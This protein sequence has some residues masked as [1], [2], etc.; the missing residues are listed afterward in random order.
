[1][2]VK[3]TA[4]TV[5]RE[6]GE[7]KRQGENDFEG[8]FLECRRAP[9]IALLVIA[10]PCSQQRPMFPFQYPPSLSFLHLSIIISPQVTESPL[11]HGPYTWQPPTNDRNLGRAKKVRGTD[12]FHV[13]EIPSSPGYSLNDLP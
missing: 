9:F 5:S 11:S 13:P 12:S 4:P 6:K 7:F 8:I 1:M 3:R 10:A 2:I